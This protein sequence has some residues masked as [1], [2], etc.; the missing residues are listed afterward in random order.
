MKLTTPSEPWTAGSPAP[1][2][3]L[4]LPVEA[5]IDGSRTPQRNLQPEHDDDDEVRGLVDSGAQ[6]EE[7][8]GHV[9]RDDPQEQLARAGDQHER[10]FDP[11]RRLERLDPLALRHHEAAQQWQYR[12]GDQERSQAQQPALQAVAQID[13][14]EDFRHL[15]A[16]CSWES[17][18]QL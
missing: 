3:A 11:H 4:P 2:P 13:L 10:Q 18:G 6:F 16:A 14:A 7:A 9:Q 8:Q 12:Q 1:A 5:E 17:V 15:H